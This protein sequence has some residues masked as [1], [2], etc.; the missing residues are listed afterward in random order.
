[1]NTVKS[2][3]LQVLSTYK[4]AEQSKKPDRLL[5]LQWVKI[6]EE[7]VQQ[8]VEVNRDT[9]HCWS[10]LLNYMKDEKL[11]TTVSLD[12]VCDYLSKYH[13]KEIKSEIINN[14]KDPN[15][16]AFYTVCE[17][18]NRQ[19]SHGHFGLFKQVSDLVEN[20]FKHYWNPAMST[21]FLVKLQ[22]HRIPKVVDIRLRSKSNKAPIQINKDFIAAN[23]VPQVE[24]GYR[25]QFL[26]RT[27]HYGGD[28]SSSSEEEIID[29]YH[30]PSAPYFSIEPWNGTRN[31]LDGDIE[32][33]QPTSHDLTELTNY[34]F[35]EYGSNKLNDNLLGLQWIKDGN[36]WSKQLI[37]VNRKE[38]SCL[39]IFLSYIYLGKFKHIS[40]SL[41][42]VCN[43]LAQ[44][45]WTE[46]KEDA[47]DIFSP[48]SLKKAFHTVCHLAN[49]QLGRCVKKKTNP[50]LFKKVSILANE[51]FG[52]YWNSAMYG[53]FLLDQQRYHLIKASNV[54]LRL[55]DTKVRVPPF[56]P[57]QETELENIEVG[58]EYERNTEYKRISRKVEQTSNYYQYPK[59]PYYSSGNPKTNR[60]T[61]RNI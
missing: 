44:Y 57:L 48:S 60:P 50:L 39:S 1:M 32:G 52:H 31:N 13:W 4:F 3:D 14:P 37:T 29:N 9:V 8:L 24:V 28:S 25:Y 7:W 46:L 18:A 55:K 53:R 27:L 20:E 12:K 19:I 17:L 26:T 35:I 16:L 56:Q 54:E 36:T 38:V 10:K 34:R 61:L 40:F 33:E 30:Y 43:Y 42:E 23:E 5:G 58:Y 15:Y 6:E 41:N 47:D 51:E 22:E 45:N 49:R 2:N 59:P 21:F 11:Q